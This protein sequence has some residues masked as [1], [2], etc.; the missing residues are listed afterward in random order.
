VK[1]KDQEEAAYQKMSPACN[2]DAISTSIGTYLSEDD[3]EDDDERFLYSHTPITLHFSDRW[4][5]IEQNED[6][7]LR[8]K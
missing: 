5:R 2:H 4:H 8:G 7:G 1:N 3:D 6:G